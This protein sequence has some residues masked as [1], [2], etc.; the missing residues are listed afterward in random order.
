MKAKFD[1][2]NCRFCGNIMPKRKPSEKGFYCNNICYGKHKKLLNVKHALKTGESRTRL[3]IT[4]LGIKRR[5]FK[6]NCKDYKNYGARGITICDSW[7]NDFFNFKDWAYKNGYDDNLT[8]ERKNVDGN[9][10]PENC[11][12]IPMSEQSKNRRNTSK[13]KLIKNE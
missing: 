2:D 3:Y 9:Y 6:E 4:W 11:T 8:I 12:W 1:S 13:N 5:C 10:C 7:L